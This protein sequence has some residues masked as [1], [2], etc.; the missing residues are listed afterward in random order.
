MISTG[1]VGVIVTV[2]VAFGRQA[3]APAET[4]I[5]KVKASA[6]ASGGAENIRLKAAGARNGSC[7]NIFFL[8]V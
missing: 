7:L 4:T 6:A 3:L 1:P 8:H 2:A 5:G